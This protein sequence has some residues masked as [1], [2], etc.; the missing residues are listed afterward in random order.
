VFFA[1]TQMRK[2]SLDWGRDGLDQRFAEAW[3][4][5]AAVVGQWLDVRAGAGPE[6]L[7]RAWLEVLGGRTPPRVG[8]IVQL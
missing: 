5:F 6:D 1:P 2:R 8:Q 3:Q 4:R 7:R